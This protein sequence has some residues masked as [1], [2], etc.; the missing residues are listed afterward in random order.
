MSVPDSGNPFG[1]EEAPAGAGATTDAPQPAEQ[2]WDTPSAP[3]TE[4]FYS[5]TTGGGAPPGQGADGQVDARIQW[6]K[7]N[8]KMLDEKAEKEKEANQAVVKQA[9]AYLAK[10]HSD[11]EKRITKRKAENAAQEQSAPKGPQ[12]DTEW[13]KVTSMINFSFKPPQEKEAERERFKQLLFAAR[14]KDVPCKV[15]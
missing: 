1:G 5:S 12:G 14:E 11:R 15:A 2:L 8:A 3:P 10:F 4:N 7:D 13:G 9:K 6:R